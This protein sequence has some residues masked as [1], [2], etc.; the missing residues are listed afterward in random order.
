MLTN[1]NENFILKIALR[2]IYYLLGKYWTPADINGFWNYGFLSGIFLVT[3]I[4]SGIFLTFFFIP[5]VDLAYE[6]VQLIMRDIS[7]GWGVRYVHLNGACV[8]ISLVYLHVSRG[9]YYGSY[10]FPRFS[11]WLVGVIILIALMGTAFLGYVLPWGQ[12]SY[13]A[14]TVITNLLTVIPIVG[15]SIT[16]LIWGG[17][18]VNEATLTRFFSLHYLLPFVIAVLAV[19]HLL[20]LH[21]P[22]SSSPSFFHHSVHLSIDF[23]PFFLIKDFFFLLVYYI[24][25]L[26][27][28]FFLPEMLN[29]PDN[30]IPANPMVTPPHIVP[31]IYFLPFY[32]ILKCISSKVYGVIMM[33]LSIVILAAL[34]FLDNN[35]IKGVKF[36][37]VREFEFWSFLNN[38]VMLGYVGAQSPVYP[39]I[40]IGIICSHMHFFYFLLFYNF[41]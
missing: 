31:E 17:F 35:R 10:N 13:W 7:Y 40:D 41:H 25:F 16:Y 30:Y 33:F 9:I 26:Y 4:I 20:L 14:A 11:V 8:F 1:F 21:L 3:Q 6:S 27:I 12:M 5:H 23:Y 22:Q 39:W 19:Y 36:N 37:R 38:F 2:R 29:H 32:G 34:P 18:S 28:V 24:P 15:K